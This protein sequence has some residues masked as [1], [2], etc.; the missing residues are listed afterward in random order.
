MRDRVYMLITFL[1]I[2]PCSFEIAAILILF[3]GLL[4]ID[5]IFEIYEHFLEMN[6]LFTSHSC[7][8]TFGPLRLPANVPPKDWKSWLVRATCDGE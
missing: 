5:V 6:I 7:A 1:V 2:L 4:S 3:F 8:L